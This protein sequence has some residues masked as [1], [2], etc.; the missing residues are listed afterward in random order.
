MFAA[1]GRI[2]AGR[3][4]ARLQAGEG[5]GIAGGVVVL[6]EKVSRANMLGL[7][8]VPLYK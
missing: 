6:H 4:A 7:R 1:H 8:L 3:G 2:G 5:G